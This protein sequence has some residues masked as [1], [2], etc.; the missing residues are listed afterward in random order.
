MVGDETAAA[1][2]GGDIYLH[3]AQAEPSY[4]GGTILSCRRLTTGDDAG[5]LVFRFRASQT[6]KGNRSPDGWGREKKIVG[7]TETGSTD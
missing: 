1:L 5:R 7:A 2:V 3:D 4:F 6:H